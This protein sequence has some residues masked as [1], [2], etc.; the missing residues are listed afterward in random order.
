VSGPDDVTIVP[1]QER[2]VAGFNRCVDAVARERRWISLVEGPPMAE[3]L[4]FVRSVNAGGG[5]HLVALDAAGEVVGWCDVAR[6]QREG[7]RHAG[8]LGIGL[9]RAF[10]GRGIGR[11]LMEATLDAARAKGIE[12]VELEVFASNTH[13]AA[14]YEHLG[15]VREGVKRRARKLDGAYDDDVLMALLFTGQEMADATRDRAR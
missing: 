4:A 3:S 11:R 8:R 5:A 14:L 15:F 12:R 9:L 1:T 6:H 10:R 7:F 13:A 2:H